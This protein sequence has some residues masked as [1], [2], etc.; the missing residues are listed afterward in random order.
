HQL[1]QA[2]TDIEHELRADGVSVWVYGTNGNNISSGFLSMNDK[3]NIASDETPSLQYRSGV[4]F[5]DS[6]AYIY[7]SGTT[8]LPKAARLSHYKL[9]AGGHILS[10]FQLSS[11]DVIYLTMPL[12]HISALFIGLANAIT[13]GST[14]VLRNKFSAT[15]FWDDCRQ[16]NVTVIIYIGELFRYLLARPKQPNDTDNKVRLAV[17][18]G[19]GADIWN[20]VKERYSI[21]QIV[22][23]YGATEGNF[24]MMN[25]DNKLGSTGCWSTLLRILCPIELVKYEYETAQ[26]ERDENGRCIKVKTGEVGLLICPVT[27]MFP[28]EG[29]VGNKDLMQKKILNN[30]FVEGDLYYNTGDLFVQ[31]NEHF[32]YFKDRLGDTFRWKGE[33]VATTEVSQVFSEFPGIEEACV[34]GVTVTGHYGKAGMAAICHSDRHVIDYSALYRLITHRLPNYA[35]PRFLRVVTALPHTSTFKQKKTN[36]LQEGFDP[37]LIPDPMYFMDSRA[38]TYSPLTTTM[39]SNIVN[40]TIRI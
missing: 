4:T 5:Q 26:P 29:Y 19:L 35:C 23:T 38:D 22:E 24:G 39:Y 21:P 18:N 30:V 31:D 7:T 3:M 16:H 12:Y 2:V 34:Y 28:L 13:A 40:G 9:L 20:E 11:Q 33:N 17:G 32:F 6:A 1:L 8:G 27:K 36:L 25:V 10:Y 37:N 15:N 14:V